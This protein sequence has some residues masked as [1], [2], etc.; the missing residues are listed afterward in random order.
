MKKLSSK[1]KSKPSYDLYNKLWYTLDLYF[2]WRI[3]S[4]IFFKYY[5]WY[6]Q[7]INI[8]KI[9][10][11][12]NIHIL[13]EIYEYDYKVFKVLLF[14]YWDFEYYLEGVDNIKNTLIVDKENLDF[15]S[16]KFNNK[17]RSNFDFVHL[18]KEKK[19][20]NLWTNLEVLGMFQQILKYDIYTKIYILDTNHSKIKIYKKYKKYNDLIGV[21]LVYSIRQVQALQERIKSSYYDSYIDEWYNEWNSEL[22]KDL[23]QKYKEKIL[24][25]DKELK[26]L[27]KKLNEYDALF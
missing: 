1:F 24:L 20:I 14:L 15:L 10:S 12:K 11:L 13:K 2:M 8:F 9:E 3:D 19:S 27:V 5:N 16:I 25:L 7:N 26:E 4:Y 6:A 22:N 18:I 21:G 23:T 17:F